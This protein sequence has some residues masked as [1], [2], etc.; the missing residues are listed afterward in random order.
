MRS[1]TFQ[2]Y[3]N[4]QREYMHSG[5]FTHVKH[6]GEKEGPNLAALCDYVTTFCGFT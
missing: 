5:S 6:V 3:Q 4:L 1:S 2:L